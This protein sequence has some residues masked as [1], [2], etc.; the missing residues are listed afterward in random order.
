MQ[1]QGLFGE[2]LHAQQQDGAGRQQMPDPVIVR[3]K[4]AGTRRAEKSEI[5]HA[6]VL[7]AAS[8]KGLFVGQTEEEPQRCCSRLREIQK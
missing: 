6:S 8:T 5:S 1:I 3:R 7:L 4:N 2:L